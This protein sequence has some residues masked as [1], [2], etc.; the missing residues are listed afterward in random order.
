MTT[1][2]TRIHGAG[3]PAPLAHPNSHGGPV[4]VAVR[5]GAARHLLRAARVVASRMGTGVRV[6][7]VVPPLLVPE[8]AGSPV[9]LPLSG[10]AE[11]DLRASVSRLLDGQIRDELGDI[12]NW[13]LE[14]DSGDPALVLTSRAADLDASL[15]LMGLGTHR[16]ID[17]LL[18]TET[19][20]RAVRH[21][22]APVLAIGAS[23]DSLPAH[24]VVATDFGPRS[25]LAAEAA[26]P[27][28]AVG[29]TV[30]L[31]H[32]WERSGSADHAIVSMEQKYEAALPRRFAA[33]QS[34]LHL[35]AAVTVTTDVL[36]G[37]V[38]AGLLEFAQDVRADLV[39]AGRQGL[40]LLARLVIGSVTTA[41]V[42]AASCALMI[43][44]DPSFADLD[45]MQRRLTGTS[46]SSDSAHWPVQLDGFTRRNTGRRADLEVDDPAIGAQS[47]ERG[48]EHV[49][50]VAVLSDMH[51][52]DSGL[53]I[54]H[55]RGQTL[56]LFGPNV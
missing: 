3:T 37:K 32:V 53:C 23:F 26:M 44:P 43:V 22:S 34:A 11:Q 21:A 4:I 14:V 24:V 20:L 31:V 13:A 29:A 28:L 52:R 30:H 9:L 51:E 18:A 15:L 49:E 55:G 7:S 1:T 8:L 38:A 10:A 16:P 41:L 39:V 56:L 46:A 2:A 40:N 12:H 42:R 17:R 45:R 25:A 27:L 48:I 33:F 50:S 35:P 19:T 54:R 5:D 6:I 36:E 47:Q